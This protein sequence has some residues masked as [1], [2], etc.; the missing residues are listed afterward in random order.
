MEANSILDI[1]DHFFIGIPLRITALQ[2]WARGKIAV[3]V[4]FNHD[5]EEE[6]IHPFT[7]SVS[8]R[9]NFRFASMINCTTS[10]S[11]SRASSR[12]APAC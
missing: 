6:L 7:S 3:A 9:A 10:F 5:R 8:R 11:F 12:V 1:D 2:G 4:F